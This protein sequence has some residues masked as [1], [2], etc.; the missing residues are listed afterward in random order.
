MTAEPTNQL[1][2]EGSTSGMKLDA[3]FLELYLDTLG[4]Q[5]STLARRL[6]VPLN[7]VQAWTKGNR[8]AP[9]EVLAW[10]SQLAIAM[11]ACPAVPPGWQGVPKGR[12][13]GSG[14]GT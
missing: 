2:N 12:R 6:R 8:S 9:P 7:T 1:D 14:N 3:R 4:W 10:L 5:A 13:K 11:R